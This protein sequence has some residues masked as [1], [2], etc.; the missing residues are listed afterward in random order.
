MTTTTT[1]QATEYSDSGNLYMAVE[2]SRARWRLALSPGGEKIRRVWVE[3][4]DSQAL[5]RQLEAAKEHFELPPE[6][7]VRSCYEAGRDG[8]WVHR[9]FVS[10]GIDSVVIDAASMKVSRRSRRAKTDRLDADQLL[11]DLVRHH[12][13]DRDVWK[14]VRIPPV[15]AEDLRRVTRQLERLKKERRQHRGRL[16]SLFATIGAGITPGKLNQTIR[17][18]DKVRCWDDSELGPCLRM[19]ITHE[20]E[21]LELVNRQIRTL[22]ALERDVATWDIP[23]GRK[24]HR[25]AQL[26]GVGL[27][28]ACLLVFELFGWREFHNRKEVGAIAGMC[29]TPYNTGDSEREQGISKAGLARVRTRMV[30]LS[31]LWLRNQPRSALSVWYQKR[32]G[33]GG[34]RARRVGTVAL[35]RKLLV[36]LWRYVEQ[37]VVPPG[38][39]LM[40]IESK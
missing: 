17:A 1:P 9:L 25:L 37:G 27:D 29:S 11:V 28:S 6:A 33:D 32:Y 14:V 26:R 38:A 3:A 12:R 40:S 30:E 34:S 16:L 8:F 21:R 2:L 36:Q 13:G 23:A 31:W 24:V 39:Q 10:L 35:A 22:E 4:G 5:L 20:A 7:G 15:K 18:L 19:E